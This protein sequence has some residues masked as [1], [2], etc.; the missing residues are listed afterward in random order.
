MTSPKAVLKSVGPKL[1]PFFKTVAIYFVLFM[2]DNNPSWFACLIKC[3]PVISL[4]IFVLLHGMSLGNE[5]WYSRRILTGL[6][7]SCLGDA[8]LI[9]YENYFIHGMGCFGVA[10]IMYTWAFGFHPFNPYAGTFLIILAICGYSF[11]LAGLA[12]V[13]VPAV[14][15]YSFLI[16]LMTW[17]AVARVQLFEDLW[18]WTKLCSCAGSI[19]FCVSDTI[20]SFTYFITP[21]PYSQALVMITYYGAQ[22]GIALSVV[23]SMATCS[24]RDNRKVIAKSNSQTFI[25]YSPTHSSE[26]SEEDESLLDGPRT[27]LRH[28]HTPNQSLTLN[29][30][31]TA[32]D[33]AN[34]YKLKV[35]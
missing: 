30:F 11:L 20:L 32:A 12:G 8:C 1:V 18:T 21:I 31:I 3:L 2:P 5:Y 10:H 25:K 6:I 27:L 35:N 26:H 17:R 34:N 24:S 13:M 9:F 33:D 14:A 4:C 23:D 22:L 15:C 28:T 19:L 16:T 7:F 29:S